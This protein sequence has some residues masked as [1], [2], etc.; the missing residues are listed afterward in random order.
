MAYKKLT[1]PEAI[2]YVADQSNLIVEYD[3][4]TK[5]PSRFAGLKL[6]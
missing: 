6:R 2:H 3:A 1:Y 5:P 4:P